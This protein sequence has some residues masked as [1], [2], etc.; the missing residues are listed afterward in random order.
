SLMIENDQFDEAEPFLRRAIDEGKVPSAFG[1]LANV[2]WDRDGDDDEVEENH[3]EAVALLAQAIELPSL[4]KTSLDMLLDLHEEEKVEEATRLLLAAAE[5]HPEN[6]TVLR[7]VASMYMDGDNPEAARPYLQRIGGL[8][9]RAPDAHA[10]A[11]RSLLA[12]DLADFEDR[13]DA[14][15]DGVRSSDQAAQAQAAVFLRELI[16]RDPRYWQPHLLLAL[17]V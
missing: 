4:H 12:L 8:Q 16:A 11:R 9:R 3:K 17:S 14:A 10:C 13:Y 1:D 15:I 7:Y 2:L 5:R 6:A